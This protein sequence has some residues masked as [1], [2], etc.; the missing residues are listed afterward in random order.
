[1]GSKDRLNA[2]LRT[3]KILTAVAGLYLV[4][5]FVS[6]A[7]ILNALHVKLEALHGQA[8]QLD[9]DSRRYLDV[10]AGLP[11][12]PTNFVPV[13]CALDINILSP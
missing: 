5:F 12:L 3:A 8:T 10:P 7:P 6:E 13:R 2:L 11:A 1:M 9:L 4:F